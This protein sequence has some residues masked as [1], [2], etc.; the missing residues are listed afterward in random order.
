MYTREA[1]LFRVSDMSLLF[2][3][4]APCR[5]L[6]CGCA[7]KGSATIQNNFHSHEEDDDDDDDDDDAM[8]M[9]MMM[10]MIM[11]MIH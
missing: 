7:L 10:M 4:I 8:M 9:M 3:K 1:C 11:I 6:A 2:R 5:T